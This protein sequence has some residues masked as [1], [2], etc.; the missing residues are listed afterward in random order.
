MEMEAEVGE[1]VPGVPGDRS[2]LRAT[3]FMQ[4]T[5]AAQET[6]PLFS[7]SCTAFSYHYVLK[8]FQF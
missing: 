2:W 1:G 7:L 5:D 3:A 4:K 8:I 6:P